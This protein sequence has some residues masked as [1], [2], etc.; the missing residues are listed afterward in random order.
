MSG[1]GSNLREAEVPEEEID[2][3]YEDEKTE[4][5]SGMGSMVAGGAGLV[6]LII[7]GVVITI[8]CCGGSTGD[9]VS[10]KTPASSDQDSVVVSP[11]DSEVPV[12]EE[13]KDNSALPEAAG[14]SAKSGSADSKSGSPNSR[15]Y[16]NRSGAALKASGQR[17]T[18][19]VKASPRAAWESPRTLA[20]TALGMLAAIVSALYVFAAPHMPYGGAVSN[21]SVGYGVTR[22]QIMMGVGVLGAFC[23]VF[24]TTGITKHAASNKTDA[25]VGDEH[26]EVSMSK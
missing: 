1:S 18:E 15:E 14:F 3:D 24:G 4:E 20:M 6:V 5:E 17:S 26:A 13:A 10:S 23:C 8:Y 16:L 2:E 7:A 25:T 11:T 19:V 21:A 9:S 12:T 22:R